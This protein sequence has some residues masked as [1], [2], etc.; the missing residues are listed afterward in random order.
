MTPSQADRVAT[1]LMASIN[2]GDLGPGDRLAPERELARHLG[3]GRAALR[4]GL[5]QLRALGYLEVRRGAGGG[6]FITGLD[7]PFDAW[8]GRMRAEPSRLHHVLD[9]RLA[10]ECGAARLAATRR[11]SRDL[12]AMAAAIEALAGDGDRAVFRHADARFHD[13]VA[14]AARSPQLAEQ[15]R[16]VRG[17]L[18]IPTDRLAFDEQW[19]STGAHHRR[20]HAAIEA[21]TPTAAADEMA[22]HIETTRREL[23][24]LVL[25]VSPRKD[26][27]TA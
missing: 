11:S 19:E 14:S 10:L 9:L 8:V 13:A 6:A 24:E 4:E 23:F 5:Q 25:G 7:L 20:I 15:V 18:F 12:D 22:A 17:E 27:R 21:G 3:V 2:S 26:R 16:A 1:A